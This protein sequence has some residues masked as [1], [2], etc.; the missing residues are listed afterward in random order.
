VDCGHCRRGIEA[1]ATC[2]GEGKL[3]RWLEI[4]SWQ[5]AAF[6]AHPPA[7]AT[8]DAELVSDT[9][10]I[11]E[12]WLSLLRPELTAD[13]RVVRQRLRVARVPMHCIHYRLGDKNHSV[14]FTGLR[15]VPPVTPNNTFDHR[16][17]RLRAL[18]LLLI[19]IAIAIAIT[20]LAR[21]TFFRN[22]TS[23]LS[24][25]A[26]NSALI[27]IYAFATDWTAARLHA[28]VRVTI[29]AALLIVAILFAV[30]AL[31]REAHA[32]QL[33]ASGNVD[34]A[35][36][37]LRFLNGDALP[38]L[39]ADV[40]LARIERT[41]DIDDARSELVQIPKTFPQYR[42]ARD[43]AALERQHK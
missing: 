13:E 39:W 14:T 41:E 35:E 27:V 26:L 11:P 22:L 40:H 24:L 12:Q 43:V 30:A 10:T 4:E 2:A 18:R 9:D 16:A 15:L 32:Q 3:Q 5:R 8:D 17:G 37:E 38:S 36:A 7:I 31:P 20:S 29:A 1:C 19:A 28:S 6:Q 34:D 33:L 42:E 23:C 21:D 25:V